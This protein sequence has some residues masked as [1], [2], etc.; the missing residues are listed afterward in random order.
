M[1]DNYIDALFAPP[2]PVPVPGNGREP[3]PNFI[4]D[5]FQKAANREELEQIEAAKREEQDRERAIV[6]EKRIKENPWAVADDESLPSH[7][8]LG[9]AIQARVNRV[10]SGDASADPLYWP[11]SIPVGGHIIG[12]LELSDVW[13]AS[14]RIE[15]DKG[16]PKDYNILAGY[17]VAE[18]AKQKRSTTQNV[19]NM[20]VGS[21][22]FGGDMAATGGIGS[23][24]GGAARSMLMTSIGKRFGAKAVESLLARAAGAGAEIAGTAA[25][26]GAAPSMLPKLAEGTIDRSMDV[27]APSPEGDGLIKVKEGQSIAQSVMETYLDN[28]IEVGTELAGEKIVKIPSLFGGTKAAKAATK[29]ADLI[30]AKV[31]TALNAVNELGLK[32]EAAKSVM[33]TIGKQNLLTEVFEERLGDIARGASG[34][35]ADAAGNGNYGTTG[36]LLTDPFGEGA[37]ALAQEA[38]VLAAIGGVGQVV[39]AGLSLPSLGDREKRMDDLREFRRQRHAERANRTPGAVPGTPGMTDEERADFEQWQADQAPPPGAQ[40]TPVSPAADDAR[41]FQRPIGDTVSP[42][43]PA[44][45]ITTDSETPPEGYINSGKTTVNDQTTYQHTPVGE[46]A[47]QQAIRKLGESPQA[48][49]AAIQTMSQEEI[50]RQ[51]KLIDDLLPQANDEQKQ[52]LPLLQAHAAGMLNPQSAATPTTPEPGVQPVTPQM[53]QPSPTAETQPDIQMGAVQDATQP[54]EITQPPL[55]APAVE[56]PAKPPRKLGSPNPSTPAP[57]GAT[58]PDANTAI[59]RSQAIAAAQDFYGSAITETTA[60]S[61]DWQAVKALSGKLG[62]E[63]IQFKPDSNL[64]GAFMLDGHDAI[65]VRGDA[66]GDAIWDFAAEELAHSTGLD[67]IEGIDE[68]LIQGQAA[69]YKQQWKQSK[70]P[71]KDK[72]LAQLEARPDIARREGLANLFRRF[73]ADATFRNEIEGKNPGLWNRLGRMIL[74]FFRGQKLTQARQAFLDGIQA[75]LNANAEQT[76]EQP[77]RQLGERQ[78]RDLFTADEL[79]EFDRLG[80]DVSGVT[81]QYKDS[82]LQTLAFKQ[83]KERELASPDYNDRVRE[84]AKRQEEARKPAIDPATKPAKPKPPAKPVA[85]PP[86]EPATPQAPAPK[87]DT[88]GPKG[89]TVSPLPASSSAETRLAERV[90][91][92]LSQEDDITPEE[93]FDWADEAFG[94]SRSQGTYG[95]SQAYDAL[96]LGVN[97][98]LVDNTDPTL[99]AT[100]AKHNVEFL[101]II[102]SRLPRHKIR[103]G[104]KDTLQQFSTPPAYAY[105]AAWAANLNEN[106]VVLEPSAGTGGLAVHAINSGA[107]VYG[108]EI[109]PAR[110]DLLKQLPVTGTFTED[111]EHLDGI[112]RGKLSPTAVVMNPPF[113]RAGHRMGDKMVTGMDRK[114]IDAALNLLP[115]GGRLVAIIGAGLHGRG[116]AFADWM[117]NLPYNIRADVEVGRDVYKGYGTTFPTRMLVIDKTPRIKPVIDVAIESPG[118]KERGES[119]IGKG[120]TVSGQAETLADLINMLE[121]VRNDRP[122]LE[123]RGTTAQQQPAKP[124]GK[125]ILGQ[126]GRALEGTQPTAPVQPPT[127]DVAVGE[128][129]AGSTK[130][131][132]EVQ[133]ATT[134]ELPNNA[135]VATGGST[136]GAARPGGKKLGGSRGK[137]AGDTPASTSKGAGTTSGVSSGESVR[138]P[139]QANTEPAGVGRSVEFEQ[140]VKQENSG[141][142]LGDSTYESYAPSARVKGSTRHPAS[143][144]ESAAMAAVPL[145]KLTYQPNIPERVVQGYKAEDGTM[146]GISDIQLEAV[147]YAGQSHTHILPNGDRRGF[148]IGD[149]T[150]V[151]KAREIAGIILDN[152]NQGRT[153]AV[154]ISKNNTLMGAAKEEWKRVGGDPAKVFAHG[155]AG[156]GEAIERKDGIL[157]SAYST[158]KQDASAKAV[159]AKNTKTR[160]DQIVDWAGED[161][162]GVIVFDESHVM[163]SAM[164]RGSGISKKKA[165]DQALAGVDLQHRL[166][167]ARIV[168]LSATSATEIENLAYATRLGLWGEGTAFADR[169][170]FINAISDGGVAAMEKLAA[171]M[172]AMGMYLARNIAFN[173]GTEKGTVTYERL[174]HTLTPDQHTAYNKMAEAWGIVFKNLREALE[175]TGGAKNGNAVRA[176]RG[177]FWGANQRFWSQVIM[178]MQ[179][180]TMIASIEKDLREGRSALVQLT[181]TNDSQT[182]RALAGLEDDADLDSVD[183]SPRYILMDFLNRSFPTAKYEEYTD[184]EGNTRTR[185][186]KDSQG[187]PVHDAKALALKEKMLDELGSLQ[188][189]NRGALDM[190]LDHFGSDMVAEVTSRPDRLVMKGGKLVREKHGAR[191]RKADID[192]FMD[193]KKRILVFSEA[194]GTGASYHADLSRKNQ[195]MRHHY[196]L[197][198]GW[199]ADAAI[200]GLGR[201]HRSNQAQAPKYFLI[202][203]NLKGQ[204]RFI[205]TI[206]RRLAQLGALT[207]GS[208]QAGESGV[209]SASDNLEST[210]AREALVQL[211]QDAVANRIPNLDLQYIEG[212]L[213]LELRD[214]E[215]KLK[216]ELPPITQFMNRVLSLPVEQQNYVF[217]EFQQRVDSRV[218]AA[219]AAGTLDQGMETIRADRIEKVS[220]QVVYTHDTGAQ[221]KHVVV[222][223]YR[224]TKPRTWEKV[225]NARV[226]GYVRSENSGKIFAVEKTTQSV[227]DAKGNMHAKMHLVGT[228]D[229][230]ST[231]DSAL[232]NPK[233]WQHLDEKAA[234]KEWQA[235]YD[236]APKL[237]K[238]PMHLLSG[239]LLPVWDRLPS[240]TARVVRLQTEGGEQILGRKVPTAEI[241]KVLRNLGASVETPKLSA[242]EAVDEVMRGSTLVL[243]NGWKIK[244]SKVDGEVAIE[245]KGPAFSYDPELIRQGVFKR[246]PQYET[247]YYI[248]TGAQA[249]EVMERVTKNRPISEVISVDATEAMSFTRNTESFSE[250]EKLN[251]PNPTRQNRSTTARRADEKANIA[252]ADITKTWERIFGVPL[253]VGGFSQKAAGLY[254]VMPEVVRVGEKHYANLA[255]AAHEIAHHIDK[256]T[257]LRNEVPAHLRGEVA[258]LDYLPKARLFEGLAEY[259]RHYITETDAA[260]LAPEFTLWFEGTWM[261]EHPDFAK[262]IKEARTHA[263]QFADQSVFQR[264]RSAIGARAPRDLDWQADK[265]KEMSSSLDRAYRDWKDQFWLLKRIQYEAEAKGDAFEKKTSAYELATAFDKTAPAKAASAIMNGVETVTENR[266]VLGVGLKDALKSL[267]SEEEYREATAYALARHTLAIHQTKP[268]YNTGIDHQDAEAWVEYVE[269][270]GDKLLRYDHFASGLTRFNNDLL[271]MLEDAGVITAEDRDR[272]IEAHGETYVPL[273]RVTDK[274]G[275]MFSGTKLANL[276]KAIMRR[277]REG[278]GRQVVDPV[279]ATIR[280]AMHFYGRAMKQQIMQQLVQEVDPQL[281]GSEG[282]G[283]W[284]D[285]VDPKRKVTSGTIHEILTTLVEQDVVDADD[286]R[287]MRIAM[288]LREGENVRGINLAWFAAR[289]GLEVDDDLTGAIDS[290]PDAMALIGLWRPDYTPNAAKSTV[291]LVIDGKPVLYEVHRDLYD[292]LAGMDPL[293]FSGFKKLFHAA[294][295]LFKA[296]AVGF[297]T[298]FGLTNLFRDWTTAQ[299]QSRYQKGPESLYSPLGWMGTYIACK[300]GAR[301]GFKNEMI[302]LYSESG[303]EMLT[304]L[305]ADGDSMNRT[306]RQLMAV[307]PAERRKVALMHPTQ[308]LKDAVQTMRE[309]IAWSDVAPRLAEFVAA[310]RHHGYGIKDGKIISLATGKPAR[311]PR[312]VIV[313]AINAAGD[314]TYN[315]KRIGSKLKYWDAFIPFL[316]ATLEPQ[317]KQV[318]ALLTLKNIGS[319]NKLDAGQARRLLVAM[320]ASAAGGWLYWLL[321]HDDDDYQEQETH[322]K[323]GYWTYGQDGVTL[324]RIGKSREWGIIPSM[325]EA[326][327]SAY[328]DNAD[329]AITDTL[330]GEVLDRIP[331]GGGATTALVEAF[332]ADFDYHRGRQLEPAYTKDEP[333]ALRST[334]YTLE[335]SKAIGEWTGP[336]GISPIQVEHVLSNSTGGVYRRWLG[337]LEKA[338]NGESL[339][340]EDVPFARGVLMN[341]HQ[342]KSIDDFYAEQQRLDL[343]AKEE[344]H[345]GGISVDT[346]SQKALFND[347][348]ALMSEI[349]AADKKDLRGRR[350]FEH[351]KYLVGLAR[352]A[353]GREPL[354]NNPSPFSADSVPDAIKEV[355]A[356]HAHEKVEGS[357]LSHGMPTKAHEGDKDYAET[358]ARFES[359]QAADDAWL[360][361]YRDT[362]YVQEAI[363]KVRNSKPYRDLLHRRG[364]PNFIHGKETWE[365][366]RAD[367]E[368]WVKKVERATEWAGE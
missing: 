319:A 177:Q 32:G 136:A 158:L 326:S 72:I 30:P 153:K 290:E 301:L 262:S 284:M 44:G 270:D 104:Q 344:K 336:L 107:K 92:R 140:P 240:G 6:L 206:A 272:M 335:T 41:I 275:G 149:G 91:Q 78:G 264:I 322:L 233:N 251:R 138:Q 31:K 42:T 134:P 130:T 217:D 39:G 273:H 163:G 354:E 59:K 317:D 187:N 271:G 85:E 265:Q 259:I 244:R 330:K 268:K 97:R 333:K 353:M 338:A 276:P 352:E 231:T 175:S 218:E 67:K 124:D 155:D 68:S 306:R 152:F 65:F 139:E 341:R 357:M 181:N 84:E 21:L 123:Q 300:V 75:K 320:V 1:P 147:A 54:Q 280:R 93:F 100:G 81:E 315:Y 161:F 359:Q 35:D 192:G 289:H 14:K 87:S 106:D 288:R 176:A 267:V 183:L 16:T 237:S 178:A 211:Y 55:P 182:Q 116:K 302:D 27:V 257:G 171:D 60:D 355:L 48:F 230:Q 283:G 137:P 142:E 279:E 82:A 314:I 227:Q 328:Y 196:L 234:E 278:S 164:D 62:R 127:G 71:A 111:A 58:A 88:D 318:R 8:R 324:V 117:D 25:V 156:S 313:K 94:G 223:V 236:A 350:K 266:R 141:K 294:N 307:T 368:R 249:A 194:G 205:S 20:V 325:M 119:W 212:T 356:K 96:E 89:D 15:Q 308:T 254:K 51:I 261:P 235:Q 69:L 329:D 112:L 299:Y 358:Y 114:H 316:N 102:G 64:P 366:H 197:Q 337:T 148:M 219:I 99:D 29:F 174:E 296:G 18:D 46:T 295:K 339:G 151:G 199:R 128:Q 83:D 367:V 90:Y 208:R 210:E 121:G 190:V 282:M 220:E 40:P 98:Y 195:Q 7:E 43:A 23:G 287:A 349:R 132:S 170:K 22:Q 4:D 321:R 36:K 340:S 11:K 103:T 26:R 286:A 45:P 203:T 209:F 345:A 133:P 252:A 184:D 224:K 285:R 179:T 19:G 159:E 53:E 293:H 346:S 108:N 169:E 188:V 70:H 160:L 168:Y 362:P 201:S 303:G 204:K 364:K 115:D 101:Q 342:A 202:H 274:R 241:N 226:V 229:S 238:E 225:Q 198:A 216:A 165:S 361:R 253:R 131:S 50:Q 145:P 79:Q 312:T 309:L 242:Q 323:R 232:A 17:L 24:V 56:S 105:V 76:P 125:R 245:I 334:P 185:P 95:D 263:R 343:Q 246:R 3:A 144:V 298:G 33:R 239:V 172:K 135:G 49:I 150:G 363:E 213:G 305:G 57:Q 38:A 327:L 292:T 200:Q 110:A 331:K 63:V 180:P 332:V 250:P 129:A 214:K 277:S 207:K 281:G 351:E 37:S 113:S 66:T 120:G 80:I 347:Y 255:V 311:P 297:S 74:D 248:P 5:L 2:A 154:W 9:A 310:M 166:P 109:D 12:A 291:R 348:G 228:V 221:A 222:N 167:K 162:D 191:S 13:Q 258:G 86:K 260:D 243:A 365:E 34:L 143:L 10:E 304:Q 122:T 247:K 146:V 193:G 126:P 186:V 215:G 77:K 157:F 118:I 73:M 61:P 360:E 28:V 173:D 189:A 52:W 269:A 256:Q 47:D